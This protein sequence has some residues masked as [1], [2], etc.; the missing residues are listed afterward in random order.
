MEIKAFFKSLFVQTF[1]SYGIHY[2]KFLW[3]GLRLN[4]GY[5][6]DIIT[7]AIHGHHFIKITKEILKAD[8]FQHK[9]A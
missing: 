2:L 1:S 5:L 8:G 3:R 4:P 9:I 7:M 6:A